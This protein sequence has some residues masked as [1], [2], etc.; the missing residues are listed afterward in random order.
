[1]EFSISNKMSLAN[2]QAHL[3]FYSQKVLW[4]IRKNKGKTGSIVVKGSVFYLC[5]K[6]TVT[7][8]AVTM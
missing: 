4:L 3:L 8:T 7:V 6:K 2:R 5:K 1:M